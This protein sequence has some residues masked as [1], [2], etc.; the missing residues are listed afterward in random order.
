[1][2][3]SVIMGLIGAVFL[4][5]GVLSFRPF[6]RRMTPQEPFATYDRRYYGPLCLALSA[7]FF[8][9]LLGGF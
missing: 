7:A 2:L 1:M 9:L 6:W 8:V 5:R 4:V 3:R